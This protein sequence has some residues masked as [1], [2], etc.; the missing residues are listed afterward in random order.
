MKKYVFPFASCTFQR[1]V[2]IFTWVETGY[3]ATSA[4]P[5]YLE[6]SRSVSKN[7]ALR[8]S[9]ENRVSDASVSLMNRMLGRIH[10]RLSVKFRQASTRS[11]LHDRNFNRE[12][13]AS[14]VIA[15]NRQKT[16]RFVRSTRFLHGSSGFRLEPIRFLPATVA[17]PELSL[18]FSPRVGEFF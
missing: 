3:Y 2:K 7:D 9:R 17:R 14:W 5:N 15:L 1:N 10:A 6:T 12:R 8:N 16:F 11:V 18:A 13:I 4:S